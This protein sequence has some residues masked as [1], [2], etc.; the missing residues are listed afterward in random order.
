MTRASALRPLLAYGAVVIFVFVA[1]IA[2][3]YVYSHDPERD[4]IEVVIDRSPP[5]GQDGEF[6]NGTVVDIAGGTVLVGTELGILE[7]TLA[8]VTLEELRPLEDPAAVSQGVAVNLGGE[9]TLS[10]RV[11][12]GVVLIAPGATP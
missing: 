5:P 1:A 6:A 9:R 4:L 12:S 3:G 10:E 8:D 11:I 7:V 2:L